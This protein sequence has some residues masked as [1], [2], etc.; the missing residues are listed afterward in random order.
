MNQRFIRGKKQE[1]GA[2]MHYTGKTFRLFLIGRSYDME[3]LGICFFGAVDAFAQTGFAAAFRGTA[4]RPMHRAVFCGAGG[5]IVNLLPVSG[6]MKL[7]I[8]AL[9]FYAW[10]RTFLKVSP[11]RAAGCTA[12]SVTVMQACFGLVGALEGMAV[13][14]ALRLGILLKGGVIIAL[15]N[16][17]PVAV[18]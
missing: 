16:L 6:N 9:F 13:I 14:A 15:G 1:A 2:K 3:M 18:Y 4:V 8:F 12:L 11:G 7:F 5:V 10:Q 17:L